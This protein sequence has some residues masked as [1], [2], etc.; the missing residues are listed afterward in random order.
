MLA[1]KAAAATTG[2]GWTCADSDVRLKSS[3]MKSSSTSTKNSFPRSEQ[4]HEI[5]D[6]SLTTEL[7]SSDSSSEPSSREAESGEAP[8]GAAAP[9]R[10]LHSARGA[11]HAA[12]GGIRR[13]RAQ[14]RVSWFASGVVGAA[15]TRINC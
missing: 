8:L 14:R 15:R 10:E 3:C 1:S 11:P 7:L 2:G 13:W 5:H 9:L 4:N 12:I 6:A